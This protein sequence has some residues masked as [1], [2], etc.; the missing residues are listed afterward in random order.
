MLL[1]LPPL[2]LR[3]VGIQQPGRAGNRLLP[4]DPL[5]TDERTFV[6][7]IFSGDWFFDQM[8]PMG[9]RRVGGCGIRDAASIGSC[10][11]SVTPVVPDD[12]T[13]GTGNV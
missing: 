12:I 6:F 3:E 11:L 4:L 9:P 8:Y 10:D 5:S 1:K 2:E 7:L 13:T